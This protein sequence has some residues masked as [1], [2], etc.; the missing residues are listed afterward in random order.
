[1]NLL[2]D[3][4]V[5]RLI[6]ERLRADG[7]YVAYVAE[8]DPGITDLEVL[9][10]ANELPALLITSDKDFGE[11]VF[12]QGLD[13]ALG[14]VLIRL[15]GVSAVRKAELVSEAFQQHANDFPQSFSV[16]SAGRLRI[17]AKP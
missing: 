7:H 13:T 3:E 4:S 10:Q 8:L 12:Q 15:S 1:M 6:V 9:Q 17:Q 2:A 16:V 11:L 14:V 5:D